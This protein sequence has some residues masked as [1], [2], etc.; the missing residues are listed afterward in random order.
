[1]LGA[2]A[3]HAVVVGVLHHSSVHEGPGEPVDYVLVLADVFGDDFV[4][5]VVVE[6][7]LQGAFYGDWFRYHLQ[8]EI[9]LRRMHIQEA[10]SL[11]INSNPR[12]SPHHL[13]HIRYMTLNKPVLRI[14]ILDR[15]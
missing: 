11:L 6:G 13:M 1:M 2:A 12:R 7:V 5:D 4:V 10:L 14:I 8:K 15:V 3:V 9:F